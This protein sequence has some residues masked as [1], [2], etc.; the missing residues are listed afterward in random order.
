MNAELEAQVTEIVREIANNQGEVALI[1]WLTQP[2]PLSAQCGIQFKLSRRETIT[3]TLF[4]NFLET[5]AKFL[6]DERRR[7]IESGIAAFLAGD[8]DIHWNIFGN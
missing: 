5:T 8:K 1:P 6:P 2:L 3:P 7:R 4:L